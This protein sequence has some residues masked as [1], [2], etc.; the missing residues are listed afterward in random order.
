MQDSG[1]R[2][3]GECFAATNE[4]ALCQDPSFRDSRRVRP[5][6]SFSVVPG[7]ASLAV[8]IGPDG[9]SRPQRLL[10]LQLGAGNGTLATE[11]LFSAR[12]VGRHNSYPDW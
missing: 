4:V 3:R 1:K 2:V 10:E 6:Q 12:N 7:A 9:V 5:L 8:A 11:L